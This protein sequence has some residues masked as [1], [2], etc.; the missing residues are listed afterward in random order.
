VALFVVSPRRGVTPH[1]ALRSPDFPPRLAAQRLPGRLPRQFY[2][3]PRGWFVT[4]A[5]V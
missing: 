5:G 2:P 3:A 4:R 1:P